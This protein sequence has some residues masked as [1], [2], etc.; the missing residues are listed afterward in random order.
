[1]IPTATTKVCDHAKLTLEPSS[2]A[3]QAGFTWPS[4]E[5]RA[6][7]ATPQGRTSSTL[8]APTITAFPAPLVLPEDELALDPKYPVQSLRSWIRLKDRNHVSKDRGTI[9]VI[10]PPS[11]DPK[12]KDIQSWIRPANLTASSEH[13]APKTQ[14]VIDYLAAFYHGMS[15]KKLPVQLAYTTWED[16]KA[17]R[18][19]PSGY[20][21]LNIGS[22][23]VRIRARVSKN[24]GIMFQK[25]LNLDDLL[26]AAISLLPSDAYALLLLVSHDIY[27]S[28]DDDFA[29]GRAYGGS[30]VA[31]VSMARYNPIL[32]EEHNVDGEHAWPAS[33]CEEFIRSCASEP[34]KKRKKQMKNSPM[35]NGDCFGPMYAA[36]KACCDLPLLPSD[37]SPSGLWL[38]RV[39]RTASHELGHCFGIDHCAYY[40]CSMQG[41]ASL[42]EDARQPPYIC[43]VDLAKVL[44]ACNTTAELR[45]RALLEYCERYQDV[46][47]FRAFAGW[48]REILFT[49]YA[50]PN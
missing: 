47:H 41:T 29:C 33:H 21:G 19:S 50:V 25:Q 40:A 35:E 18:G 28:D 5:K 45:Y 15:V 6:A 46:R 7:A 27:E 10:E 23:C 32:D 39:C 30:R 38:A 12:A 36:L 16:K 43:P 4:E 31:V 17:R 14:E 34:P 2:Y 11:V 9:Y 22:E 49:Q 42:G 8:S 13:E 37:P 3:A 26:D 1:M 20:I 48:I 24:T 44:R